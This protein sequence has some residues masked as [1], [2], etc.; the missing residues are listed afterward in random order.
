MSECLG[1]GSPTIACEQMGT[2]SF[3]LLSIDSNLFID[4]RNRANFARFINHSCDPNCDTQV[5]IC[6]YVLV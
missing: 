2:S 1:K 3:Y 6:W 5:G 4:A